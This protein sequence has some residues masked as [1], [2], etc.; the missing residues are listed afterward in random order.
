MSV[1]LNVINILLYVVRSHAF[2][3]LKHTRRFIAVELIM[4]GEVHTVY[5]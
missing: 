2:P 3:P 4:Y 1:K 5:M